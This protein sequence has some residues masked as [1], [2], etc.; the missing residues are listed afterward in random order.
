[1]KKR[2]KTQLDT[3]FKHARAGLG[4]MDMIVSV[5][6][7]LLPL[8]ILVS[9]YLVSGLFAR[10]STNSTSGD[11]ARV[12][13]IGFVQLKEHRAQLV[14]G[15]YELNPT[16][17]VYQNTY[18]S[19]I[20]GV[21][22]AKDPYFSSDEPVEIESYLYLKVIE[23]NLP[24]TVTYE[25]RNKWTLIDTVAD[26]VNHRIERIYAY[27]DNIGPDTDGP[28]YVLKHN[29]VYVSE[30]YAGESFDLIFQGYMSQAKA[31]VDAEDAYDDLFGGGGAG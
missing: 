9:V 30:A 21:D 5:A 16:A 3:R 11:S 4:G 15:E 2:E 7:R 6:L 1:M 26:N 23:E 14:D 24:S 27:S 19:V 12:A 10:Y 13:S 28:I 8:L 29:K 20:P 18:S 22:I 17:S 25:L 31:G